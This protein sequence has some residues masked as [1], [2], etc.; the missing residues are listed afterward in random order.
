MNLSDKEND[1]QLK[2]KH[3]HTQYMLLDSKTIA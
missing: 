1:L 3:L 2:I